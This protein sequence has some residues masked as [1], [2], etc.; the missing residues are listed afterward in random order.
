MDKK[1]N[2]TSGNKINEEIKAPEV[3]LIGVDGQP[4][5]IVPTY[6]ALEIAKN[7]DLDLVLVSDVSIPPVCKILNYGKYR[8]A[9]QKKKTESRKKQKTIEIKEIQF[10]PFIGENDLNIK[11]RAI[12]RFIAEG[13]KVKVVMRFRGREMNRTEI[14]FNIINKVLS[15]CEDFA[16]AEPKPKLEGSM[17]VTVL[18]KK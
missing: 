12:Q 17:I 4:V 18:S 15:F 10:R 2:S 13:N 5:G 14:G 3:R 7:A 11:C 16:K 9:I 6:Q 8:Y 1:K